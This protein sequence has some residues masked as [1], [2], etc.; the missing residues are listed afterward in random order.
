ME[1]VKITTSQNIEIDYQV[2]RLGDRV[3]ARIIDYAIFFGLY[4]LCIM[5][6]IGYT[7]TSGTADSAT[8]NMRMLIVVC[9]W[10]GLCVFYDLVCELFFNGQSIGKHIIKIKVVSLNGARPS[11][12]QYLLRWIFR[13]ID[14]GISAG[15]LAL[16][17]V[18]LTDNR[19]RVGDMVAGTTLV[20]TE[21]Q[22][23][24]K[25]LFFNHPG[26]DYQP[27]YT[28]VWQLTDKDI[29]LIYDV[30]KNFNLTR[31]SD[32]VYKLALRIKDYLKI[33]YPKTINEYQF[34]EIVVNDYNSLVASN[35]L[36]S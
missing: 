7:A 29:T 26:E 6:F 12:G 10:L 8:S 9:V 31:N 21:P 34:L 15:S 16:V 28:E 5:V 14:F 27:T 2:A 13:I 30:I 22:T 20:K 18:A 4:M 36:V 35:G 23:Q 11:V 1:T 19:Q 17:S 33:S 3:L 24:F 32:L 25:D